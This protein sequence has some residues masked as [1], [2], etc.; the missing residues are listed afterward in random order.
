[1]IDGCE[2]IAIFYITDA[3]NYYSTPVNRTKPRI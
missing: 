3:D 1:M 2:V